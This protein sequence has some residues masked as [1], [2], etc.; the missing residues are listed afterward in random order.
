MTVSK[1][2]KKKKPKYNMNAIIKNALRKVWSYHPLHK[3]VK[4]SC[5]RYAPR[6]KKDGTRHKVDKMIGYECSKCHQVV[7]KIEI[8]HLVP[9]AG[10]KGDKLNWDRYVDR[11][12]NGVQVGVCRDCHLKFHPKRSKK[13]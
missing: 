12:F 3:E 13:K 9:V 2:K 7:E 11:L 1:K 10:E 5:K 4:D 8:H 6:F